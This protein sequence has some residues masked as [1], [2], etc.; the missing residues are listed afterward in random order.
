[1]LKW[2]RWKYEVNYCGE[3]LKGTF[4]CR[5]TRDLEGATEVLEMNYGKGCVVSLTAK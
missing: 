2:Y 4:R 3:V 1:M 5:V